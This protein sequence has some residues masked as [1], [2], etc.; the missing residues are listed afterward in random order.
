MEKKIVYAIF[1]SIAEV[2]LITDVS[3][4]QGGIYW[5]IFRI[6]WPHTR[7]DYHIDTFLHFNQV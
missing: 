5:M 2:Q 4:S 1:H 7:I 6:F 3:R